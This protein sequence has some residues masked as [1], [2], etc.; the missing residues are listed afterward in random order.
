MKTTVGRN[1]M[2]QFTD[3][4]KGIPFIRKSKDL[5]RNGNDQ[6]VV[7]NDYLAAL[8]QFIEKLPLTSEVKRKKLI[9]EKTKVEEF[10]INW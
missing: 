3:Q 10:L 8:N 5:H 6:K 4:V 1:A 9:K 7:M 2:Y